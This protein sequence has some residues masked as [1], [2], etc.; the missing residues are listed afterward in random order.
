MPEANFTDARGVDA[1]IARLR[2]HVA[3]ANDSRPFFWAVGIRK[4][5]L[6]WAV[7]RAFLDRQVAQEGAS[8]V[9]FCGVWVGL[10]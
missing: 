10:Y 9:F 5:H 3:G 8:F 1:A 2:G 4:P 6:D 7:P